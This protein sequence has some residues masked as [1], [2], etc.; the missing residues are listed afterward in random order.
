MC[1]RLFTLPLTGQPI[2]SPDRSP[3]DGRRGVTLRT[4]LAGVENQLL[5][6]LA[7]AFLA[8]PSGDDHEPTAW[9]FN[10]LVL[11][12]PTGAGKSHLAVGLA[13]AWK[14]AHPHDRVTYTTGADF[15]QRI[16]A[17]SAA[18]TPGD[19]SGA[20]RLRS[21]KWTSA[22]VL[23]VD[24]LDAVGNADHVQ[25]QFIRVLDESLA[26]GTRVIIT[27]KSSPL[28]EPLWLPALRS[29]LCGGMVLPVQPPSLLVRE[30]LVR[31]LSATRGRPLPSDVVDR[32]ARDPGT[33]PTLLGRII[34]LE[35]AARMNHQSVDGEL[36]DAVLNESEPL[37]TLTLHDIAA[38][39]VVEFGVSLTD[40][41]GPKRRQVLV[42]ARGVCVLLGRELLGASYVQLG[43][44]LGGRDHTTI[45][46]ARD[47][48]VERIAA[49]T[50]LAAAVHRI[51]LAVASPSPKARA[52]TSLKSPR[53]RQRPEAP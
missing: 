8:E 37:A 17:E 11:Y 21:S 4:F 24:D 15:A 10:P 26:A 13:H 44:F 38:A 29:R 16:A 6:P 45:I 50:A 39:A 33:A 34:R 9:A 1:S 35:L 42:A 3:P 27:L 49:D 36:A 5:E 22:A 52:T 25:S 20:L 19:G 7:A 18:Q 47:K 53:P 28:A 31:E 40:M 14:T 46:H 2:R 41:L 30:A 12:G 32:I 51:R 43:N 23:V 48:T